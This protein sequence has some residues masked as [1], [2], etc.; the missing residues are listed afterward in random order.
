MA[1]T[2]RQQQFAA[3][4]EA[5]EQGDHQQA[6]QILGHAMSEDPRAAADLKQAILDHLHPDR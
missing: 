3:A 1:N 6:N 5:A 2:F 4:R